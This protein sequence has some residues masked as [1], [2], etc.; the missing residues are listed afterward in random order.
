MYLLNKFVLMCKYTLTCT[1]NTIL[2][3]FRRAYMCRMCAVINS[4]NNEGWVEGEFLFPRLETPSK[5]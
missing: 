5:S 2:Q 1:C 3:G 4:S